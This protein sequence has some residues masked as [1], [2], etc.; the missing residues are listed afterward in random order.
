MCIINSKRHVQCFPENLIRKYNIDFIHEYL[1]YILVRRLKIPFKFDLKFDASTE[2][3]RA[4]LHPSAL[5]SFSRFLKSFV[6]G[7]SVSL[8][9]KFH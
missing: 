1:N 3:P 5:T 8:V 4:L 2:I 9:F 7:T 6:C